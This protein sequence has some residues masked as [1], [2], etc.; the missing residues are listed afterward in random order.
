M[1]KLFLLLVFLFLIYFAIQFAFNYF[2]NG[3]EISYNLKYE[4][5]DISVDE[6]YIDNYKNET[7][8]YYFKVSVNDKVFS[9]QT[10]H[11]FNKNSYVL[12]E[13]KYYQDDKYDCILPIFKNN[14]ILF[15]VMCLENN[16]ITYYHNINGN[17]KIDEFVENISLESYKVNTWE[18]N[19]ESFIEEGI[20]KLY[21]DN[22]VINHY[23]GITHYRGLYTINKSNS[24]SIFNLGIFVNDAYQRKIEGYVGDYYV[25]ANYD[26]VD[27]ISK[28]YYIDIKENKNNSIQ[29]YY[30]ISYNSYIQ[31]A[32]DDSIYLFDI[33]NG[34]QYEINTAKGSILEVGNKDTKIKHYENGE[35]KKLAI[36][37]VQR[38]K[39]LFIYDDYKNDDYVR[40]D[41]KGNALSGYYYLYKKVD[42]HYKVYRA[43]IQNEGILTYLFD[44]QNI[45]RIA[46]LDDFIYFIDGNDLK[47]FSDK[48]G[49]KTVLNNREYE[50][51]NTLSFNVLKDKK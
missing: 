11:N 23:L 41:K 2:G 14:V 44:T 4:N 22:I 42:D 27:N 7:S 51:N 28:F 46:Y 16:L 6:K 13:I 37:E 50:F 39:P 1:K 17:K 26:S 45:E 3:H 40:S 48:T 20:I 35:W 8:N 5:I 34:I 18:D 49:V 24:K 9:F 10:F 33:D 19:K 32:I 29:S 25:S 21:K 43:N 31:G 15:D 36:D 38:D 30:A 47:Y 12:K